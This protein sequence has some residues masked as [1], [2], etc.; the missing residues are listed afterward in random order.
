MKQSII[1]LI[2]C[3]AFAISGT[4]FANAQEKVMF[5]THQQLSNWDI[6]KW[7]SNKND[8]VPPIIA[9]DENSSNFGETSVKLD[10]KFSGDKWQ[11]GIIE[12][13]GRFDLTLYKTISFDV[14][15]PKN[16]PQGILARAIIVTGENFSWLEM[17]KAVNVSPGR[18]TTI[19]AR[20][21]RGNNKWVSKKGTVKISDEIKADIRKIAIRIESN[22]AKYEGPVYIDRIKFIK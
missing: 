21:K 13:E 2:V 19:K 18:R 5:N 4:Y 10:V 12:T 16:A 20:I 7:S 22:S 6:P 17:D 14:Y 11:A 1:T 3:A 15:L 9:V 8:H